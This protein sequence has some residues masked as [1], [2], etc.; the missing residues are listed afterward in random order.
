ME[1]LSLHILDIVENSITA[2]ADRIEI[3]IIEDTKANIFSIEIKD[4]GRGMDRELL[5]NACDPFYTTRTTR[6]V[7]LGIPMLAQAAK[8]CM[9]DIKVVSAKG[10][11]TAIRVSFQHNHIDRKPLGDMGKTLVILIASNP[12]IDFIY[13]HK[14][15]DNMYTLDTPEIKKDLDGVP[16]STP[17]VIRIIK[18]DISAWLNSRN[19]MI[20]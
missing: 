18:D 16:I 12:G 10:K 8:E 14:I 19:N 6:R 4:N 3:K 1:D 5:E 2:G 20:E 17:E 15:N 13:E 7:G 9:G 11:G